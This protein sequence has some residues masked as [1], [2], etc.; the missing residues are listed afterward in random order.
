MN[1]NK[2][3]FAAG[4]F[5]GVEDY[6]SKITGVI[7]T[8]VG[9][10]GGNTIN[11]SYEEVCNGNTGHAECV[12]IIFNKNL[13]SYQSLL[14]NFWKCHDPTTLNKQGNDIGSQYRSAIFYFDEIQKDL[15]TKSK[16][17][18]S[19]NY[20][21]SIVTEIKLAKDFFLAED[22]HQEYLKKFI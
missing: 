12:L 15:A 16:I 2:A 4:C 21:N 3:M 7:S 17:Q 1:N 13:I 14:T 18:I 10:S 9:Y 19:P 20:N 6:F 22:Y 8:K 11:P 5:W